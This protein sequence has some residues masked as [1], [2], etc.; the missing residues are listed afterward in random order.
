MLNSIGPANIFSTDESRSGKYT[1]CNEN[2]D[3]LAKTTNK[4]EKSDVYMIPKG[5]LH[6]T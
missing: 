4:V 3:R 2:S 5:N 6:E 1:G